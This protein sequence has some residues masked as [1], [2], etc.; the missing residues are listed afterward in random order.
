MIKKNKKFFLKRKTLSRRFA[1]GLCLSVLTFL[2]F[3]VLG[4]LYL[5][6]QTS[7]YERNDQLL[8]VYMVV[9]FSVAAFVLLYQLKVRKRFGIVVTDSHIYIFNHFNKVKFTI[10]EIDCVEYKKLGSKYIYYRFNAYGRHYNIILNS[11]FKVLK[12]LNDHYVPIRRYKFS[13][14]GKNIKITATSL[15][16]VLALTQLLGVSWV[17]SSCL[18]VVVISLLVELDILRVPKSDNPFRVFL[19][20][21][22]SMNILFAWYIV[23]PKTEAERFVSQV[24]QTL[25]QK[26]QAPHI[27]DTNKLCQTLSASSTAGQWV[28][29]ADF[30]GKFQLGKPKV[31]FSYYKYA[32]YKSDDSYLKFVISRGL[33]SLNERETKK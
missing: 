7:Y 9:S 29:C 31:V 4:F 13:Q 14:L 23:S 5:A 30:Y 33:A 17:I 28:A 8:Y 24:K 27:H 6:D 11:S 26:K 15:F 20:L 2:L 18:T 10:Y 32:Q 22:L 16:T 25:Q 3:N 12:E 21:L 19:V 1:K